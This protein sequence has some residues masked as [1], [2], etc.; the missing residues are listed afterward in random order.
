MLLLQVFYIFLV[1]LAVA[2]EHYLVGRAWK[3]YELARWTLGVATVM[4]LALPLALAG[5]IDFSTWLLIFFG[6][7]FAGAITAGFA[8]HE[9][10]H[11]RLQRTQQLRGAIDDTSEIAE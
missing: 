6:F 10:A 8:I 1:I 5:V 9:S 4:F 7:G 11:R 3:G 2:I